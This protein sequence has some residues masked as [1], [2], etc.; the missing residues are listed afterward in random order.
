MKNCITRI[1]KKCGH[2]TFIK[3]KMKKHCQCIKKKLDEKYSLEITL[4][5]L[6]LL[7][8]MY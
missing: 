5:R 6:F 7:F 4:Q 2:L 3:I 8:K 1:L